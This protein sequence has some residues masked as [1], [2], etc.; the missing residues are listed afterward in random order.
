MDALTFTFAEVTPPP[1]PTTDRFDALL[2]GRCLSWAAPCVG[3]V[4][5]ALLLLRHAM[6]TEL[7]TPGG[8]PGT[9]LRIGGGIPASWLSSP[10]AIRSA[11]TFAGPVSASWTPT[12]DGVEVTVQAPD[13]VHIEVVA[14][15]GQIVALPAGARQVRLS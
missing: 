1:P 6:V 12:D 5:V 7:P 15:S 3:G 4:G 9:R 11:P 14:P 2:P 8:A 10:L 13:H